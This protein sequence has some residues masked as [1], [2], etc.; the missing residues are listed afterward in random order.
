MG[1][2]SRGFE[3]GSG[4]GKFDMALQIMGIKSQD[5]MRAVSSI[6]DEVIGK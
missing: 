5:L 6:L 2:G 1:R 4:G 3:G